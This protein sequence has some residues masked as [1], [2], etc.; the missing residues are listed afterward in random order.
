MKMDV[1][2]VIASLS[3]TP[4]SLMMWA[5]SISETS[6]NFYQRALRN[7]PDDSHLQLLIGQTMTSQNWLRNKKQNYV[8]RVR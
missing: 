4:S 8:F 7:S 6:V 1:F 3:A 2:W 5:E